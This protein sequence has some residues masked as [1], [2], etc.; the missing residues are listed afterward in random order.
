MHSKKLIAAVIITASLCTSSAASAHVVVNPNE[1]VTAK[2]QTFIVSV[3]NEKN[4]STTKLRLIVP[5]EIATIT[6]TVK[7]GWT[8][9]TEK[10]QTGK[11]KSVTWE[12]GD[13]PSERRDE[14]TFSAKTP[15]EAGDIHW[16]TYQTYADGTVVAW[17]AATTSHSHSEESA[18]G[19]YSTTKIV[20]QNRDE[21]TEQSIK[22]GQSDAQTSFIISIVSIT[23]ALGAVFA[24]TRKK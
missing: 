13:I 10:D 5:D 7:S 12:D 20:T 9:T 8:I 23:I 4:I 3:P 11:L 22:Q 2:H 15:D 21:Q 14:F 1:V 17:D 24:A 6:P 16:K 18:A 19:P